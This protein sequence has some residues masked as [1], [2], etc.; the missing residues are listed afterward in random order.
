MKSVTLAALAAALLLLIHGCA[1]VG[2]NIEYQSFE[3]EKLE[4]VTPGRTTAGQVATLFGAPTQVVELSGGNA[5]VYERSVSKATGAYF[6]L[7]SFV[8]YDQQFDRL[9]FFFDEEN[10]LTHYGFS[11]KADTASYGLPF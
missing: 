10:R 5:Y 9:V 11:L 3:P 1:A 2:K 8:R 4:Q 7:I 6:V